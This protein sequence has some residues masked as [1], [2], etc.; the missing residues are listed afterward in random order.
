MGIGTGDGRYY[1]DDVSH[2]LDSMRDLAPLEPFI[3]NRQRPVSPTP[4]SPMDYM[5][6]P[7]DPKGTFNDEPTTEAI[8]RERDRD[9]NNPA[10]YGAPVTPIQ[11][12]KAGWGPR[13]A[14]LPPNILW[15]P[16]M[17]EVREWHGDPEV[18]RFDYKDRSELQKLV[19]EGYEGYATEMSDGERYVL[20]RKIKGKPPLTSMDDSSPDPVKAGQQYAGG[21]LPLKQKAGT[22]SI[23]ANTFEERWNNM[24]TEH[25]EEILQKIA[26]F[27]F[28]EPD[29]SDPLK[30]ERYQ[31]WPERVV[32]GIGHTIVD[33]LNVFG[34]V[35]RGERDALD[36]TSIKRMFDLAFLTTFGASPTSFKSAQGAFSNIEQA[37]ALAH[38]AAYRSRALGDVIAEGRRIQSELGTAGPLHPYERF[39]AQGGTVGETPGVLSSLRGLTQAE[40][41]ASLVPMVYPS[42][43]KTITFKNSAGEE[44]IIRASQGSTK[45]GG[46]TIIVHRIASKASNDVKDMSLLHS[47][48]TAG[49]LEVLAKVQREFP[50]AKYI[51]GFRVTG[52]KPGV[53]KTMKLPQRQKDLGPGD[54]I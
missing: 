28:D 53:S 39:L 12:G 23:P 30:K 26:D 34:E 31:L 7:V 42:K 24:S 50:D 27:K 47:M 37:E 25:G 17:K 9:Q 18:E 35:A 20:R 3:P 2:A 38:N 41:E 29:K 33:G 10:K 14:D 21:D 19:P 51:Q 5:I 54:V 43:I 48:G 46:D 52:A 45:A 16:P 32:R 11:G 49:M 8:G 36:P 44:G 6:D 15:A 22:V 1:E 13:P 40:L 4:I